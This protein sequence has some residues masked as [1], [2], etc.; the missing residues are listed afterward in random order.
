[1]YF[2]LIYIYNICI[3]IFTYSDI[4]LYN[5]KICWYIYICH[6]V[7]LSDTDVPSAPL[8]LYTTDA[9][10][11]S[12]TLNWSKP[13][14]GGAKIKHY[15]IERKDTT[16]SY[17]SNV[18]LVEA[19]KHSY[20]VIGLQDGADYYFRWGLS[21]CFSYAI[22]ICSIASFIHVQTKMLRPLSVS[23]HKAKHLIA[24]WVF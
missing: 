6:I 1:M 3:Y 10:C 12:L 9:A 22:P 24:I 8:N 4:D 13:R 21:L 14:G 15:I 11:G 23:V 2:T 7:Y 19:F 16:L 18:A 17:W 5:I 20:K